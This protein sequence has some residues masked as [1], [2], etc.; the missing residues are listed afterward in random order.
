M[1]AQDYPV[2]FPYGSTESP[3]GT[4]L[5]PYHRGEDRATPT[6]TE[7]VIAGVTAG[8]TGASGLVTGPHLHIQ[9]WK[10]DVKTARKPQ[11]SFKGGLVTQVSNNT[12]QQWGRHFT[13]H[14]PDGW[15]TTYCHLLKVNIKV[16]DELKEGGDVKITKEQVYWHYV[17]IR[18]YKPSEKELAGYVGQDYVTATEDIKKYTVDRAQDYMAY[19]AKHPD[20][21]ETT[22]KPGLYRVK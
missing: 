18:G 20:G 10:G 14:N 5:L 12:E 3:Y 1:T 8:L 15:N 9:E 21:S 7:V 17:T 11:H 2:T 16:G 4:A 19:R 13:I 22:L 6:G